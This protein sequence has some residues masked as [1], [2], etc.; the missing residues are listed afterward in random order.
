MA[1]SGITDYSV[2]WLEISRAVKSYFGWRC[3]KCL[4]PHRVGKRNTPCDTKCEH[5][6]DGKQRILTI[7]HL[8]WDK[9]N[10]R[11]TNLIPLCQK[12][13]LEVQA[14]YDPNQLSMFSQPYYIE[15]FLKK[16]KV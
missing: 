5:G 10:N 4:H 2:N 7:H 1:R 16:L 15:R 9:S 8:D 12:C 13:H 11:L 3:I 14:H 6:I